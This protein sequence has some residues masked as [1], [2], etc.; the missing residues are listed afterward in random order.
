MARALA[1]AGVN[2]EAFS[3]AHGNRDALVSS[4]N[5]LAPTVLQERRSRPNG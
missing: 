1:D 2:I 3:L 5:D 4:D